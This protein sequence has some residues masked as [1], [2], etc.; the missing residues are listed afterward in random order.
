MTTRYLTRVQLRREVALDALAPLL[1]GKGAGFGRTNHSGHHLVWYLFAD[2]RDRRRDFLWREA[3][4]RS[5]YVLAAR[6]PH[7]PHDLFDIAEPKPFEPTLSVGDWLS[8]SLRANPVVRRRSSDGDRRVK[9]DVVMHALHKQ[10]RNTRRP[11]R[12][13]VVREAGFEWL[14]AQAVGSGFAVAR[15]H[16][17]I[18]RYEQ[19]RIARP[20]SA[21]LSFSTLDFEG[22]LQV[23]D[24][25][26]LVSR[27]ELGFGA[28]RAYGCGLMLVRR[29]VPPADVR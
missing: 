15:D 25:G 10:R 1:V 23:T 29:A 17:S 12:L 6:R 13:N 26:D 21:P 11:H 4:S 2:G 27:I 9:H 19:H 3:G 16:V 22:M 7:D 5:F 24:P 18:D 28:A 20:G 14:A 8:F